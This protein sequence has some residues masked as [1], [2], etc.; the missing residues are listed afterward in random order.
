[1][2]SVLE[3]KKAD[4][5]LD[6]FQN[7]FSKYCSVFGKKFGIDINHL[8]PSR[9]LVSKTDDLYVNVDNIIDFFVSIS[10][11]VSAVYKNESVKK[12]GQ[13]HTSSLDVIE[14]ILKNVVDFEAENTIE[15]K[16]LEPSCG[17]GIF[18]LFIIYKLYQKGH[19]KE[20]LINF[21]N[22]NLVGFDILP[23]MVYFTKLNIQCLMAYL[24]KDD[25]SIQDKLNPR[26]YVT[27]TTFKPEGEMG[28]L[29]LFDT[30][31]KFVETEEAAKV[32]LDAVKGIDQFDYV[33]GNPPYVTLYGRRD[34]KKQKL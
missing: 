7:V 29:E 9:Q 25:A 34:K 23:E 26:I 20:D 27:D 22:H 13:F 28:Q 31:L 24:F 17:T 8:L 30:G 32:K 10:N 18:L 33:V 5:N 19:S 3:R 16:F 1:M 12:S 11:E 21:I 6:K 2:V 4:L 14:L 15:K